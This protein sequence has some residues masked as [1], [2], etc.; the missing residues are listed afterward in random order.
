MIVNRKQIAEILGVSGT[1]IEIWRKDNG[2]PWIQNGK[3]RQ[4]DAAGVVKWLVEHRLRQNFGDP[5]SSG[6]ANLTEYRR[7]KTAEEVEKLRLINAQKR[8]ELVPMDVVA[9][10]VGGAVQILAASLDAIPAELRRQ[11]PHLLA[12]DLETVQRVLA[13]TRNA[14]ADKN[15]VPADLGLTDVEEY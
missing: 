11:C 1:Q 15:L 8:G 14:I 12:S 6:V 2:L 13:R 10:A 9:Q 5:E 7:R 4:Y 3:A